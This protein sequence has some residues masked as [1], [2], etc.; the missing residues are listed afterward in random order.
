MVIRYITQRNMY[1]LFVLY[2][3][4][5]FIRHDKKSETEIVFPVRLEAP[6]II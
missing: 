6:F 2:I 4:T 1:V 5:S 3:K